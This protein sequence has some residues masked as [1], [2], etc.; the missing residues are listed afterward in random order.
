MPKLNFF[1]EKHRFGLE[2]ALHY[3]CS[4]LF[5]G[6]EEPELRILHLTASPAFAGR[7]IVELCGLQHIIALDSDGSL[8]FFQCS[9]LISF[10]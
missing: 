10:L 6:S 4:V 5:V 8:T 3:D 7:P 2:L 9:R 1:S